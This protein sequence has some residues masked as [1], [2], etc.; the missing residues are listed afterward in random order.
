MKSIFS[1][2][3][4]VAVTMLLLGF[5]V[6]A[7]AEKILVGTD[8]TFPPFE[9]LDAAYKPAGFDIDLMKAI[10]DAAGFAVEFRTTSFDRLFIDL[11]NGTIGAAISTIS[12]LDERRKIADFSSPYFTSSVVLLIST[13]AKRLAALADFEGMK[14]GTQSGV[15]VWANAIRKLNKKKDDVLYFDELQQGLDALLQGRIAGFLYD[16]TYARCTLLRDPAYKGKLVAFEPA[17]ADDPLGIAVKKGNEALLAR[18][19]A[20]LKKIGENGTKKA[21]ERKWLQ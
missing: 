5:P 3:L 11:E 8:P 1:S 12:I 19:N 6:P 2:V 13:N 18:I 9:K 14:V 15:E 10:G 17:L 16:G 21:I 7:N 4:G 20:G